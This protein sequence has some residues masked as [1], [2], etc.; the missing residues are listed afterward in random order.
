MRE[1]NETGSITEKEAEQQRQ[2]NE[3]N[4]RLAAL[5]RPDIDPQP[6]NYVSESLKPQVESSIT[7]KKA[8][9]RSRAEKMAERQRRID[10]QIAYQKAEEERQAMQWKI[11]YERMAREAEANAENLKAYEKE[12]ED[13]VR[14]SKN[15]QE[16]EEEPRAQPMSNAARQ[17]E[18]EK[19][20]IMVIRQTKKAK[21]KAEREKAEREKAERKKAERENAERE[22]AA[23]KKVTEEYRA[24]RKAE[25]QDLESPKPQVESSIPNVV[26]AVF[27]EAEKQYLG[28]PNTP[29][30]KR[31]YEKLQKIR[32]DNRPVPGALSSP[33]EL[34]IKAT[35][36]I[37][38]FAYKKAELAASGKA[39]YEEAI[40]YLNE[41]IIYMPKNAELYELLGRVYKQLKMY[42]EARDNFERA[43]SEASNNFKLRKR[44]NNEKQMCQQLMEAERQAKQ[45]RLPTFDS[46][47][48]RSSSYLPY[49]SAYVPPLD[50]LLNRSDQ[51]RSDQENQAE[52]QAVPISDIFSFLQANNYQSFTNVFSGEQS[53]ASNSNPSSSSSSSAGILTPQVPNSLHSSSSLSNGSSI[54]DTTMQIS[55]REF[56]PNR[57]RK[58]EKEHSI[59]LGDLSGEE[60]QS[61]I[62]SFF[63]NKVSNTQGFF[64]SQ[65]RGE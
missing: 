29:D 27:D 58:N 35:Y 1:L 46:S 5:L 15:M 3:Y 54:D 19:E 57:K 52:Q 30:F 21:E 64:T 26:K 59:D 16:P 65:G 28:Q 61:D 62:G 51:E 8:V 38:R 49:G 2:E 25:K 44:L 10:K 60:V 40:A 37:G 6:R 9:K 34:Y 13:Y 63:Q 22:N 50:M 41:A 7:K 47:S 17:A 39:L 33:H 42:P 20:V 11:F 24:K 43:L 14:K 53:L 4:E 31:V 23:I 12:V 32:E 36:H 48:L 45:I 56:Q 18:A 55:G